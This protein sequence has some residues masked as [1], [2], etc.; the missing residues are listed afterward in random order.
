MK[1][2]LTYKLGKHTYKLVSL[3]NKLGLTLIYT[4]FSEDTNRFYA[5]LIFNVS[6]LHITDFSRIFA[7]I[8]Q[9]TIWQNTKQKNQKTSPF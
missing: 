7:A 4:H 2:I 1:F 9:S 3:T 8:K 6:F 5:L